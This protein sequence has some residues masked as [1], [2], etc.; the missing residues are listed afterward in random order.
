MDCDRKGCWAVKEGTFARWYAE[1]YGT[2]SG[3]AK[4]KAEIF[5]RGPISCGICVTNE[6]EAYEGGIFE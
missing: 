1:E 3:V 4:M 5:A 6:F 2:V